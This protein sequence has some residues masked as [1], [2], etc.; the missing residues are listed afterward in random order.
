MEHKLAA[1]TWVAYNSCVRSAVAYPLV[2]QQ[3]TVEHLSKTQS[4]MDQM[5]CHAL[6]LNEHFPRALLYGPLS[7]GGLGL[8]TLWSEALAE[9]IAYFVHHR[10]VADDV[11]KHMAVSAAMTQLEVGV[12]TPFFQLPHATWG[13]LATPSWLVHLWQ[14]C[15]RVGIELEAAIGQ[16]WVPPLQT[17]SDEYIMDRVMRRYS[18]KAS[19]KINH[20]RRF[21][22][23]V[24]I[25]DIFLHDGKRFHPDIYRG[26]RAGGRVTTY[27]WPEITPPTKAC[28]TVWK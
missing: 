11:G 4:V 26:Q 28:W 19:I 21:L 14:S 18:R 24:T 13:H 27:E 22:Q 2:G 7:L 8:P 17:S 20:C 9:K 25:S 23:V 16:H 15:S 5:A 6:G 3:C 10:R 1:G 12:G